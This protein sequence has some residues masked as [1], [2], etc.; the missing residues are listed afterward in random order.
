MKSIQR[1]TQ[2][3]VVTF[4]LAMAVN[5]PAL[6]SGD[7]ISGLW[8]IEGTPAGAP[9]PVFT[10]TSFNGKDGSITNIDPWFGTGLGQWEKLGGEQYSMSFTH[11]FLDGGNVGEVNVSAVGEVS[12]NGNVMHGDFTTVISINGVV[13][14]SVVG[15]VEGTRQ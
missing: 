7:P 8:V 15:T 13:V 10:N 2:T 11:Y 5:T 3:L 12:A 14:G 6:A 1:L 9:G 4:V